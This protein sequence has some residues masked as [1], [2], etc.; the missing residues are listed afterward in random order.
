MVARPT[1]IVSFHPVDLTKFSS[2]PEEIENPTDCILF[3]S[4][5]AKFGLLRKEMENESRDA[6]VVETESRG[7]IEPEGDSPNY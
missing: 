6:A 5:N 3:S 4:K 1:G 7:V 2:M